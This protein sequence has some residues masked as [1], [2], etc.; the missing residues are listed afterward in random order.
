MTA[1]FGWYAYFVKDER[2]Q[3]PPE[4]VSENYKQKKLNK[5]LQSIKKDKDEEVNPEILL[6]ECEDISK[7]MKKHNVNHQH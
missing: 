3:S 2:K 4:W 5:Y 6:K 1:G 7:I